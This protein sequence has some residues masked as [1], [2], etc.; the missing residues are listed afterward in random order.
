VAFI[1]P[2]WWIL[3]LGFHR[4]WHL[5]VYSVK[6]S[7]KLLFDKKSKLDEIERFFLEAKSRYGLP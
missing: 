4:R 5:K 7:R 2:A 6:G 1:V 3:D